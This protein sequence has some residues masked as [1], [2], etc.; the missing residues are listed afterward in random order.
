MDLRPSASFQPSTAY[1]DGSLFCR[2]I[3]RLAITLFCG[4]SFSGRAPTE[5]P[6]PD[7]YIYSQAARRRHVQLTLSSHKVGREHRWKARV[8]LSP[9]SE[10]PKVY[11][12]KA[13]HRNFPP[14]M[15]KPFSLAHLRPRI[16]HFA[17]YQNKSIR[18]LR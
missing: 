18:L 3:F 8:S 5:L 9:Y 4:S 11:Q 17:T 7:R 10:F 14:S 1:G 6:Q 12:R 15:I 2:L 16:L 13:A